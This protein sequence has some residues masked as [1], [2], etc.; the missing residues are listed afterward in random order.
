MK[1]DAKF[2]KFKNVLAGV[3]IATGVT[4]VGLNISLISLSK[5]L[6]KQAEMCQGA[7]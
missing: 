2:N 1:K 4:E 6:I 5:K 7:F 3:N